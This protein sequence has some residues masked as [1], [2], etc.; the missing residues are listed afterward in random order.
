MDR[1][2]FLN[3]LHSNFGV[4]APA[5]VDLV[6]RVS[7][8]PVVAVE[9]LVAGDE[10]EVHR[11]T[12]V[13][14]RTL[15]A[16]ISLPD[17]PPS[18][19]YQEARAMELARAAGVPVPAV[20]AAEPIVTDDHERQAMVVASA[21]G[22]QLSGLLPTLS[23]VERR[24]T[25]MDLGRVLAM[26]HSVRMPG[27]GESDARRRRYLANVLADCDHLGVAGFT[28]DEIAQ[29]RD[30][31]G[32]FRD[33]PVQEVPVLCHG[34]L[35]PAHVFVDADLR[36]CGLIDW[37]MWR[38]GA[39]VDDMADFTHR[40]DRV[41]AAAVLV[42]HYG[43]AASDPALTRAIARSLMTQ[44]IGHLRWLITSGQTGCLEPGVGALRQALAHLRASNNT[45]GP[46]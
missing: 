29:I 28:A 42:G 18:K 12:L 35:A 30:L 1:S 13:D 36:V 9:R 7:G 24:A 34:D 20:L 10:Y 41:D 38:A 15:F 44:V 40:N 11:V 27:M 14:G 32:T 23:L 2:S 21:P 8:S 31:V 22:R 17:A 3:E 33:I 43:P 46:P 16:R 6:R 45:V 19:L 26:L 39:A 37:G 25:M 5:V 4:P